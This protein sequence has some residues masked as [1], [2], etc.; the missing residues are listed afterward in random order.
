MKR[1]FLG[2]LLLVIFLSSVS[3]ALIVGGY[4]IF[5]MNTYFQNHKKDFYGILRN[6]LVIFDKTLVLIE[7]D[8]QKYA[9][10]KTLAL[11]DDLWE[12]GKFRDT[13]KPEELHRIAK[14]H[15]VSQIGFINE[16]GYLYNS[17]FVL[18]IGLDLY[19]LSKRFEMF[20]KNLT[21]EGKVRGLR[22][23]TSAT[24]GQLNMYTY[25]STPGTDKILNVC[26]HV[27]DFVTRHYSKEYYDFL[28][29]DFFMMLKG[30]NRYLK[31][32][33]IFIVTNNPPRM[34][35]IIHEG[36]FEKINLK[37]IKDIIYK[38][39]IQK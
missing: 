10:E 31:N 21:G 24:T 17:S 38:N 3:V 8:M 37:R 11:A 4:G 22:I 27:R 18:D 25:Y 13:L 9:R 2:Y 23:S 16:E 28:F 32:L 12:N 19:G 14:D 29:H 39:E 33:D 35:S 30:E 1:R 15:N 20:L 26:L 36:R 34:W 6:H 7:R 5:Q